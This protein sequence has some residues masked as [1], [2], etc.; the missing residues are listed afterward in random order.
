MFDTEFRDNRSSP[1]NFRRILI[2]SLFRALKIRYTHEASTVMKP[3][4]KQQT[5]SKKELSEISEE[6]IWESRFTCFCCFVL[7]FLSQKKALN[8]MKVVSIF[9]SNQS[10]YGVDFKRID[11]SPQCQID[12]SYHYYQRNIQKNL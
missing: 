9:F 10:V 6:I 4:I 12:N 7:I 5:S 2:F 3:K 8:V 1:L 11:N